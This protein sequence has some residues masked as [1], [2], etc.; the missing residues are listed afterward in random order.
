MTSAGGRLPQRGQVLPLPCDQQFVRFSEPL[1]VKNPPSPGTARQM[2]STAEDRYSRT[3]GTLVHSA[4][5]SPS[6]TP[7]RSGCAANRS[8]G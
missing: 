6:A 3:S 2:V 8:A 1:M 4:A 5:N 7:F